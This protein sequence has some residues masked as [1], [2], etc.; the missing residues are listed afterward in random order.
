MP[1]I[2]AM[3]SKGYG[4]TGTTGALA[5]GAEAFFVIPH[6]G[7]QTPGIGVAVTITGGATATVEYTFS[8]PDSVAAGT[9]NWVPSALLNGAV[10]SKYEIVTRAMTGVHIKC[11]VAGTVTGEISY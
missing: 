7:A 9:A 10:A 5:V 4:Y 8:D 3:T 1:T 2:T 11:T 6:G